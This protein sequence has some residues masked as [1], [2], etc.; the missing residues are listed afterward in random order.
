[1]LPKYKPLSIKKEMEISK[2]SPLFIKKEY[3]FNKN[4]L[5]CLGINHTS[6]FTHPQFK[7][8]ISLVEKEKFSCIV[9]EIS[10]EQLKDYELIK[11][12]EDFKEKDFIIRLAK[13]KRIPLLAGDADFKEILYKNRKEYGDKNILLI[14]IL[15]YLNHKKNIE[16]EISKI[17]NHLETK[18]DFKKIFEEFKKNEAI[19]NDKFKEIIKNFMQ[20]YTN[21]KLEEI[22]YKD[23]LLPSPLENKTELN[24]I[25]RDISYKRDEVMI[26]KTFEKLKKGAVLF[27]AGKN[28]IIRQEPFLRKLELSNKAF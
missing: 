18:D 15:M 16:E 3:L 17:I 8:I 6:E 19:T 10:E 20:L 26:Q 28:H 2:N 9:L 1:M 22:N 13:E 14:R 5:I 12:K 23:N 25:I 27:I 4:K 7:E 24:K 11:N 21:K